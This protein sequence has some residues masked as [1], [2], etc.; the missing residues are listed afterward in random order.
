MLAKLTN[1]HSSASVFFH[2]A[3]AV[4]GLRCLL[5]HWPLGVFLFNSWGKKRACWEKLRLKGCYTGKSG[6]QEGSHNPAS[7]AKCRLELSAKRNGVDAAGAAFSIM[8]CSVGMPTLPRGSSLSHLQRALTI[9]SFVASCKR[10]ECI[11]FSQPLGKLSHRI[12]RR[13]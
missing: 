2:F 8:F 3:T 9:L 4:N 13:K 6:S 5:R 1:G 7:A 11:P 12:R 10:D